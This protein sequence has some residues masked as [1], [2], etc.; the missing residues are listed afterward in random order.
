MGIVQ[1]PL[2]AATHLANVRK[3]T[4]VTKYSTYVV[5]TCVALL[6]DC[7]SSVRAHLL[8]HSQYLWFRTV[9]D[10]APASF[11]NAPVL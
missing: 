7:R 10:A 6:N 11:K 4:V 5:N 8:L 9:N 1:L 3:R 2:G